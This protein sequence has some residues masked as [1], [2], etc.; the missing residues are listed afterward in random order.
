MI[1]FGI[2]GGGIFRGTQGAAGIG[3]FPCPK[4]DRDGERGKDGVVL[5]WRTEKP[6][7]ALKGQWTVYL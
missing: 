5:C 2:G 6:L 1:S 3:T 4:I 7:S